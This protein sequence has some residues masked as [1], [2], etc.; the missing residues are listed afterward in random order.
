MSR[1]TH[2]VDVSWL[3]A[4]EKLALSAILKDEAQHE[5]AGNAFQLTE[6]QLAELDHRVQLADRG[7]QAGEPW[8]VTY[9]RLLTRYR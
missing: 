7:E 5:L 2:D 1:S 6:A 8:D 3:S 9:A 4:D